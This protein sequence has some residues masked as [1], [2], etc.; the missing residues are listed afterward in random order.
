MPSCWGFLL[1]AGGGWPIRAADHGPAEEGHG[2]HR[3]VPIPEGHPWHPWLHLTLVGWD[4]AQDPQMFAPGQLLV[5]GPAKISFKRYC[6]LLMLTD[7]NL[8]E[9]V[10]QYC[11]CA[12]LCLC[13]DVYRQKSHSGWHACAAVAVTPR[14]PRCYGLSNSTQT[15]ITAPK[16]MIS[17]LIL[18]DFGLA[19]RTTK[20]RLE[21]IQPNISLMRNWRNATGRGR[22]DIGRPVF[23]KFLLTPSQCLISLSSAF[24][25]RS[26]R[27]SNL[28]N[29][30]T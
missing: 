26:S 15:A 14:V 19:C 20:T 23:A 18:G 4:W 22:S 11:W 1:D 17:S 5:Q 28:S 2:T 8:C 30:V 16:S 24:G 6:Q 10:F 13:P 25:L 3:H 9:I 29:V 27:I 21:R 12:W 7:T